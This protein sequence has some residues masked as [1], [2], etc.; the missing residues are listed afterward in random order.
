MVV[1]GGQFFEAPGESGQ[2]QARARAALASLDRV[3]ALN[4][5]FSNE[6]QPF[7]GLETVATLRR[8]SR[9][10]TG[11]AGARKPIVTEM[12]D[13]LAGAAVARGLRW[14][15]YIN[16]DIEVTPAAV[17]RILS[18]DRDGLGICRVDVDPVTREPQRIE[19]N[20]VDM[21]AFTVEWWGRE[22][23]RFRDYIAGEL[24]WDNVYAAILCTHGRA[25]IVTRDPGILHERHA[26]AW[27]TGPFADYNGYLAAL[28]A[29]YF[30]R[31]VEYA[32]RLDPKVDNTP[33]IRE[34]F[35][36]P[37]P[38]TLRHTLRTVRAHAR[39]TWKRRR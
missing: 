18:S 19:T 38:W 22:R 20:G 2:R 8:D 7:A 37:I 4:L 29:P 13:A 11:A 5:Q 17:E 6:A 24:G 32:T 1:I 31:W 34:V 21:F 36:T 35:G 14:F 16:A 3:L 25:D 33:L 28:D 23:R 27:G 12:L 30:S 39:Y 10:V 9:T 15:A 26:G